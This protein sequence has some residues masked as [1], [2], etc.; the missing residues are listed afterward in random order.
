M[1][2]K[3]DLTVRPIL[4]ADYQEVY[5]L[6]GAAFKMA[7]H[8]REGGEQN[9]AAGLRN[10]DCYI[11]ELDLVAEAGGGLIGHIMLTKTFVIRPGGDRYNTLMLAP[12]SVLPKYQ[13]LH[14]GSVLMKEGLRRAKDLGYE[15]V[16]L[17]G[18]YNYYKKFGYKQASLYGIFHADI[19]A[20][21][22]LV[23]EIV[24]GALNGVAGKVEL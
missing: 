22:V 7:E 8:S 2:K 24:P 23:H 4:P 3:I 16:F 9:F 5:R 1:E 6:I 19:S 13:N 11:P 21:Y 12:L 18:Y 10:G 17:A 15:T 20:E 14:V